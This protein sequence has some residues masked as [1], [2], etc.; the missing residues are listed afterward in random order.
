[1]AVFNPEAVCPVADVYIAVT[2]LMDNEQIKQ[3]GLVDAIFYF[4]L[5]LGAF[6]PSLLRWWIAK[7]E[8]DFGL[9][10]LSGLEPEIAWV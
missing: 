5:H 6:P 2:T 3:S 4:S 8:L 7:I 10:V 1:L 9:T